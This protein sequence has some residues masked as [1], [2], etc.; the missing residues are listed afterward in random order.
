M[1]WDVSF[2]AIGVVVDDTCGRGVFCPTQRNTVFERRRGWADGFETESNRFT[3]SAHA[4][5][6]GNKRG[7]CA[8]SQ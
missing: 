5:A 6:G 4:T 1:R 8:A 2:V 7:K 3:A